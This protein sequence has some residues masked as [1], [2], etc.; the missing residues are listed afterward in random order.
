M[1][2]TQSRANTNKQAAFS[3]GEAFLEA[4]G[5]K[6]DL[7]RTLLVKATGQ[8][9]QERQIGF[10]GN[11]GQANPLQALDYLMREDAVGGAEPVVQE[12]KTVLLEKFIT[13]LGQRLAE[14]H[15][16]VPAPQFLGQILETAEKFK[17]EVDTQLVQ[18]EERY[19]QAQTR[20]KKWQDEYGREKSLVTRML[21]LGGA[22]F[23]G[24]VSV[25]EAGQLWN[26]RELLHKNREAWRATSE[27][28]AT[29]IQVAGS[30]AR[31]LDALKLAAYQAIQQAE[32]ERTRL[33]NELAN[34][35]PWTYAVDYVRLA[36]EFRAG[37][38]DAVLLAE[39]LTV[40]REQGSEAVAAQARAIAR[41]EMERW[42]SKSE[43]P[44][45]IE[46]EARAT[47]NSD[48]DPFEADSLVLVGETLLDQVHWQFPTWQ[49]TRQARPRKLTLQI[50]PTGEPLFENPNLTT[51]RYGER[52]DRFGF[53][54]AELDVA[55]EEIKLVVECKESFEEA[56]RA[57]EYY[58]SEEVASSIPVR[59]LNESPVSDSTPAVMP[60][61][62]APT[63]VR[64]PLMDELVRAT[65]TNRRDDNQHS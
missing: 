43:L 37:E 46:L 58:I 53:L 33:E 45:L 47:F 65:V 39:L 1:T 9:F 48:G 32:L 60:S 61:V 16:E 6:R 55:L 40:A 11:G 56:R 59:P 29:V 38:A 2:R 35:H 27:I 15:D 64:K 5:L 10:L 62:S 8:V 19:V 12:N 54:D 24:T 50:T 3:A 63:D 28:W 22:L 23:G 4:L 13:N 21:A 7:P 36:Q 20:L 51:A 30:Y 17:R 18:I 26:R 44:Q 52:N 25:S 34:S 14:A 49:L 57:R 41:R 42:M 31:N